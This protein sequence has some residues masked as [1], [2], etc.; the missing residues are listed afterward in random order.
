MNPNP[1][2][3]EPPTLDLPFLRSDKYLRGLRATGFL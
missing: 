2:R 3:T 1:D